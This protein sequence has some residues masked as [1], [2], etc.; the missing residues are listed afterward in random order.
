M[1]NV[2]KNDHGVSPVIAVI[3]MVAIT[4]VLA[5]VLYLW[6]SSLADTD[7][8]AELLDIKGE[9]YEDLD[10]AATADKLVIEVMGGTITWG[11]YK[12]TVGGTEVT[13]TTTSS[14]AGDE[15]T[16]TTSVPALT[17][18]TSYT[19]KIVNVGDNEVVWS[20]DIIAKS[21]DSDLTN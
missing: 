5:G 4:V 9:L 10:S 19:V 11:D 1:K 16:F 8:S 2:K 15:E 17:Q 6:V 21:Y 3:L 18:G 14:S 12:V 20:K 7:K 13:T